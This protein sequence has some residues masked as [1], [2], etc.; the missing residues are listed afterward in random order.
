LRSA[1]SMPTNAANSGSDAAFLRTAISRREA[2]VASK[3][4]TSSSSAKL[5]SGPGDAPEYGL[6]LVAG[7][8][9]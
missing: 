2:P 4:W 5:G 1:Q 8:V 7:L 3:P 9:L 6:S